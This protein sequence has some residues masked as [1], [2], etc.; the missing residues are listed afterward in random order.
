VRIVAGEDAR[1]RV[2]PAAVRPVLAVA[3]A[4]ADGYDA[5]VP[6]VAVEGEVGPIVAG[7]ED[8][9]AAFAVAPIR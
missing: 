5:G 4:G 8:D 7:G 1:E 9:D 3:V 2:A 6:G